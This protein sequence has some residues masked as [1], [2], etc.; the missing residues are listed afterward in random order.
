MHIHSHTRKWT[1]WVR[2]DTA[3]TWM[4]LP[5]TGPILCMALILLPELCGFCSLGQGQA[6]YFCA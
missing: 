4:A 3:Q 1:P 6:A 2:K 5:Y